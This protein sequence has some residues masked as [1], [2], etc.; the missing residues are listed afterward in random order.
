M[1]HGDS[2]PDLT[3]AALTPCGSHILSSS[4]TPARGTHLLGIITHFQA[5]P[6][7]CRDHSLRAASLLAFLYSL[8]KYVKEQVC[9][10]EGGESNPLYDTNPFFLNYR[11]SPRSRLTAFPFARLSGLSFPEPQ[12]VLPYRLCLLLWFPKTI[13]SVISFVRLSTTFN[14][15]FNLRYRLNNRGLSVVWWSTVHPLMSLRK[16][17]SSS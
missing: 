11:E 7:D 12:C 10:W 9:W 17:L 2:N 6:H 4:M 14:S 13:Q 3:C 16:P 5:P 8:C 1:P 15:A